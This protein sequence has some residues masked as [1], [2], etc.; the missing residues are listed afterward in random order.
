VL[1][2]KHPNVAAEEVI[3]LMLQTTAPEEIT[4]VMLQAGSAENTEGKLAEYNPVPVL[5]SVTQV[6]D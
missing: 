4:E 2:T 3:V 5:E 1:E 6:P